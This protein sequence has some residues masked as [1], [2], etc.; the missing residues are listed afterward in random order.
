M[1]DPAFR[2]AFNLL[3]GALIGQGTY[4]KVFE[5]AIDPT[6]V[7]K[8]ELEQE[9]RTFPNHDEFRFWQEQADYRKVSDWLA[10][11]VRISPDARILL[12]KRCQPLRATDTLPE[13]LPE[14]LTDRKRDNFGWYE[15]RLVCLDYQFTI[16]NSPLRP[17]K[18]TW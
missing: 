10:P 9:W 6:L 11:C 18:V 14:F 16:Y 7:V 5:C 2:D 13:K 12:Q 3:C 17:K 8:V 1:S 4:R 15:G